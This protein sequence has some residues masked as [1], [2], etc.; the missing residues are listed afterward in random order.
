MEF[1]LHTEKTE[2][3]IWVSAR[4]G[5]NDECRQLQSFIYEF[6][7]QEASPTGGANQSFTF[8]AIFSLFW[9]YIFI[10]PDDCL[11][12][13]GPGLVLAQCSGSMHH[14]IRI[15]W[16]VAKPLRQIT[17]RAVLFM[18][19][20]NR[21]TKTAWKSENSLFHFCKAFWLP[22]SAFERKNSHST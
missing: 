10:A 12:S 2:N 1:G 5:H 20:S 17:A 4:S 3:I 15:E 8:W 11:G 18:W 16:K 6:L 7:W 14:L 22:M 21:D 9:C 13:R 19:E